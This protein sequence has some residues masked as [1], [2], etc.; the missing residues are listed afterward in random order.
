MQM[1]LNKKHWASVVAPSGNQGQELP[2]GLKEL[3]LR[4]DQHELILFVS[5]GLCSC[6]FCF[7]LPACLF[8]SS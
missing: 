4:T 2:G 6:S 3:R 7:P 5:E 8:S 1:M